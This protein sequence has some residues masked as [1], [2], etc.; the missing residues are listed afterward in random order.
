[1]QGLQLVVSDYED[2]ADHLPD[3]LIS[4]T[5]IEAFVDVDVEVVVHPLLDQAH[6]E[7]LAVLPGHGPHEHR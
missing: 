4:E 2:V 1:M 5:D 3:L 7:I 6:L